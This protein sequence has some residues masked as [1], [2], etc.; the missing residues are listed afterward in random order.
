MRGLQK[1]R[2]A[3]VSY[4]RIIVP[5]RVAPPIPTQGRRQSGPA[6]KSGLVQRLSL[7]YEKLETHAKESEIQLG[8]E[9]R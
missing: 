2:S 5:V 1:P 3:S 9:G 4:E 6:G 7:G 8:T